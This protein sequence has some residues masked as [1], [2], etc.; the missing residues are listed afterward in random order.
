M[1]DIPLAVTPVAASPDIETVRELFLEYQRWLGVDLC[2]QGFE[3]E[4]AGLPGVYAPPAGRLYL[5]RWK[6]AVAGCIAL[7]PLDRGIGE[8]KRL[9]VRPAHRGKRIGGALVGQIVADAREIG[10]RRLRLDTLP[11]METARAVYAAFGF[12]EIASYYDNPLPGVIY[13]ELSL[14]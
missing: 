1:P 12:R 5:A 10:Y 7:R 11:G 13:M 3:Q 4:L 9:Y 8:V 6:G 2:F 14:G